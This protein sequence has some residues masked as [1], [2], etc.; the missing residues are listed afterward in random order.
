[1]VIVEKAN[2]EKELFSEDKLRAS[3]QRAGIPNQLH[4][5]VIDHIT[6]KLYDGI[7]TSQIYQHIIEFL[8]TSHPYSKGRYS[9]K[10]ALMDLGPTGYP[11]ED[12]VA[13]LMQKEGYQTQVRT[14]LQGRCV[15]HE[16]D[17]IAKKESEALCIE[18]KFHN[19][20]G[21]KTDVQVSLYTKARF[22]DVRE[23]NHLTQP[24]LIT[25]TKATLEAIA[26][27]ECVGMR[28]MTWSYPEGN[29]LRDVVERYHLFPITAIASL[30]MSQK[31]Q[32]LEQQ[33]VLCQDICNNPGVLDVFG[34]PLEKKQ[35]ILE[36]SGF[37]C[38]LQN[39]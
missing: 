25:N 31:Q 35:R 22:D 23:K 2:G 7:P 14:I 11:F 6:S 34:L 33:I 36:E 1:M 4:K 27:A 15:T 38:R 17:V 28:I 24:F 32:L 19:T 29:A 13:K 21:V 10:Q 39:T 26:Y 12:Y 8:D 16:I 5:N 37:I 9:L 30:S 18:A 20:N 3:I